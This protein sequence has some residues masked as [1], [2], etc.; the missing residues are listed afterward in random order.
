VA[1]LCR[2]LERTEHIDLECGSL[3]HAAHGLVLYRSKVYG[4]RSATQA[5]RSRTPDRR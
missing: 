4:L 1:Y 2:L 3:Y 5:T